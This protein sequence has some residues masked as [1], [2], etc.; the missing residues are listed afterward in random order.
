M[1]QLRNISK[2]YDGNTVLRELSLSIQEGEHIAIMGK[3]GC[4]KT[5]LLRIIADLE[6]MDSGTRN[7]YLFTDISF[8]FQEPRLFP[9]LTVLENLTVVCPEQN[10][11][12][13]QYAFE[14]LR[15]I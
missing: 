8:V 4:G 2:S 14:L 11:T 6:Q 12:V 3:S 5:T 10:E 7:G 15:Q 1:I 9:H 13:K